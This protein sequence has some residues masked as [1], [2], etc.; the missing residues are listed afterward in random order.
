MDTAE[1]QADDHGVVA[2]PGGRPRARRRRGRVSRRT[3]AVPRS[4]AAD[5][6]GERAAG[7]GR[8]GGR[9]GDAQPPAASRAALAARSA[10]ASARRSRRAS[11]RCRAPSGSARRSTIQWLPSRSCGAL[12]T[13]PRCGL[14]PKSPQQA[15]GMRIDRRRRR[16]SAPGTRP[17]GDGGGRAPL[18]PPGVR[19]RSQGLRVTPQ[20]DRLGER[21]QPELGHRRLADDDRAGR[22]AAAAPPRR[23]RAPLRGIAPVPRLVTSPARSISSLTAT[24]T[25]SS[26][27]L[28]PRARRSSARSASASARSAIDGPEGVELAVEPV[29]ALQRRL[30]EL[31][32][33]R[34]AAAHQLGLGGHAVPGPA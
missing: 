4:A 18:E 15:A 20:R 31:A 27:P 16:P 3:S 5:L 6:V 8:E 11:P 33:G 22:R 9:D 24:G 26:G 25:P 13:R 32:R 23:R 14:R 17:R 34:L 29:D 19:S 1:H 7:P 28:S 21:P 30:G 12:G 2:Q 10:P